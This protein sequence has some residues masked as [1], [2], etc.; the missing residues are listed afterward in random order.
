MNKNIC[1][2][3]E[4]EVT[5]SEGKSLNLS[6]FFSEGLCL[7]SRVKSIIKDLRGG[8]PLAGEIHNCACCAA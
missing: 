5:S 4:F 6:L 3:N 2:E 1:L 7:I 8:G